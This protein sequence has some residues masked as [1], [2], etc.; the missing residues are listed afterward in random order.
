MNWKELQSQSADLFRG[1]GCDARVEEG[2]Q[3]ARGFHKI[4]VWVVLSVMGINSKWAI[5]CKNWNSN[6]SKEKVL[7]LQSIIQDVGADKGVIISKKGFQSG[8]VRCAQNTNIILT[9]FDDLKAIIE[10]EFAKSSW[11]ILSD[12]AKLLMRRILD[13]ER[14][15]LSISLVGF[16]TILQINLEEAFLHSGRMVLIKSVDEMLLKQGKES[17]L[18][19]EG[20]KEFVAHASYLLDEVQARIDGCNHSSTN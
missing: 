6:V 15:C 1:L 14:S 20:K 18:V 4:D 5:E 2:V 7:A 12:R 3:G 16:T 8:A 9:D 19:F 10:E 17:F 13:G 11:R